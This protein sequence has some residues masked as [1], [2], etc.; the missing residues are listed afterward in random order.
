[1]RIKV[2]SDLHID[3]NHRVTWQFDPD[4]FYVI[5]GDISGDAEITRDFVK[6]HIKQGVFVA[7]NHLGYS[8]KITLEDSLALLRSEFNKGKVRFLNNN[9]YTIKNTVFIGTTLWTDFNLYGCVPECMEIAWNCL[10]DYRYVKTFNEKYGMVRTLGP[11]TTLG[12]FQKN[13]AYLEKQ[14][15]KY[16]DKKVVIVTHH[17]P[18][19]KS[20]DEKYVYDK[21]SA[22]YASNLEWLIEKYDNIVLW[23]HGHVHAKTRYRIGHTRVVCEPFGYYN[24]NLMDVR[25]LGYEINV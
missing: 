17:A 12:Y 22:A 24:E 4:T 16:K 21:T 23:C 11:I 10:N 6:K 19:L 1:M 15:E 8:S 3:I 14:L 13:V 5:C 20:I 25:D 2:I 18:S 9:V 7:G